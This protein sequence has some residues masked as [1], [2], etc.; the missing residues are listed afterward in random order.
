MNKTTYTTGDLMKMFEIKWRNTFQNILDTYGDWIPYTKTG[1][2]Y[3]FDSRCVDVIQFITDNQKQSIV[4]DELKA[5]LDERFGQTI[6]VDDNEQTNTNKL[7]IDNSYTTNL[8]QMALH[9]KQLTDL[10]SSQ[11]HILRSHNDELQVRDELVE[12]KQQRIL[13]LEKQLD[14]NKVAAQKELAQK[15]S[16][17][18]DLQKRIGRMSLFGW[19]D[20][21]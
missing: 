20:K 1:K 17:V 21:K 14:E 7:T 19:R 9:A 4:G 3:V 6:T 16:E 18:E 11:Q 12:R 10:V 2:Q 8:Q 5:K 15:Q 13:E